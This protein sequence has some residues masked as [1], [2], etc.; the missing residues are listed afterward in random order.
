[1]NLDSLILTLKSDLLANVL[2]YA[3]D[4]QK[5][6]ESITLQIRE[7]IATR[8][9][10]VFERDP[11]GEYRLLAACP[12]RKREIF[13]R[14]ESRRLLAIAGRFQKATFL[15]PGKGGVGRILADLGMK[16]SFVVPL[17]VGDES[18]GMLILLDLMDNQGIEQIL[19]ALK[20]VAGLLSLVFKNSFLFRNMESL[21]DQRTKALQESELRSQI[22]LQTA[23]DG[24]WCVDPTGSLIE[25]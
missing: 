10:A 23:M 3:S 17:R 5:C 1:M 8:V 9:V 16:E 4:I 20:D 25:G 14:E 22:I 2:E 19:L 24:F 12:D 15:Q 21:V 11:T 6:A 13:N 7:M 18:F